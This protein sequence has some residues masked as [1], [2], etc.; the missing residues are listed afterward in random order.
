MITNGLLITILS[1][2]LLVI[3]YSSITMSQLLFLTSLIVLTPVIISLIKK[4]DTTSIIPTFQQVAEYEKEK[5]GDEWIR[6]RK[7]NEIVRILV[8]TLLFLQAF[9][10]RFTAEIAYDKQTFP[11]IFIITVAVMIMVNISLYIHIRKVDRAHSQTELQGYTKKSNFM[12]AV[13]MLSIT[14]FVFLLSI[15]FVAYSS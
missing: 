2:Y 7:A 3:R 15:I 13:V 8:G 4:N 1:S 9:Y 11:V 5:M 12:S 10:W 14:I 6:Q